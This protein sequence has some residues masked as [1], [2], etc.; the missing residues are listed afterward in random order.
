MVR[1][2]IAIYGVSP[3]ADGTSPVPLIPAMTLEA[4]LA[5]VKHVH[6]GQGV[7]RPHTFVTGRETVLGLVPLGYGDVS[8]GTRP[9]RGLYPLQVDASPSQDGSAWTS[10]WIDLGDFEAPSGDAVALFGRSERGEP[11]AHEWAEAAGND[12]LRDRH[13]DRIAG[14]SDLCR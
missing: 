3:F 12:R 8:R 9:T 4:S 13:P 5:L 1:P 14:A 2:G 10:S 11:T 7:G 6:A